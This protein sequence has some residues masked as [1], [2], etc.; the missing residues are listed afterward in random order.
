M[1]AVTAMRLKTGASTRPSDLK[2]N[3]GGRIFPSPQHARRIIRSRCAA[4]TVT[5]LLQDSGR[6]PFKPI[7]CRR[8][9]LLRALRAGKN[10]DAR[11]RPG[12]AA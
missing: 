10:R 11:F 7:S 1:S 4:R 3:C 2:L 12:R 8:L 6:L 5:V 9:H